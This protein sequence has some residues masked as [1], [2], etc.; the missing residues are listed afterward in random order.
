M[1]ARRVYDEATT[2]ADGSRYE[3]VAWEVSE[4]DRHPEGIR[5][6]FQYLGPDD[7]EVLRYDNF[8]EH[9]D[10]G[11]HHR[12]GPDGSV[13]TITFEGLATHVERF[14]DEVHDLAGSPYPNGGPTQ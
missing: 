1:T 3:T 9:P 2:L 13:E 11:K 8:P 5:Y 7:G 12:H 4:S 6:S 14:L 10:V